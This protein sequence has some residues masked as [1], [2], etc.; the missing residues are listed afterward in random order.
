M[1]EVINRAVCGAVALLLRSALAVSVVSAVATPPLDT[2]NGANEAAQAKSPVK[3]LRSELKQ[4]AGLPK[5]LNKQPFANQSLTAA[6]A[7]QAKRVLWRH[8][9]A[10]VKSDLQLN[11]NRGVVRAA[12]RK[13]RF[14]YRV[15]GNKPAGG[16]SLFISLH[17]GG[18]APA[19]VNDRQWKNQARLYQ[20]DEG[21]Y[22]A[23]RAPTNAWNLWHKAHIDPLLDKLITQM[24]VARDVNPNKVY[25]LGYSAGGDGVYQLAPRM[26]D[27]W[28]AAS[29]MA[30]HPND[31]SIRGLRNVPFSIHVGGKDSAYDRNEIARKRAKKLNQLHKQ[32]PGGYKHWTPRYPDKGHWLDRED[33]RALSWMADYTRDPHPNRVVWVQDDVTHNR[34]YWLKV[35]E[36]NERPGAT[37]VAQYQ[38][39]HIRLKESSKV[40]E[41][42]VLL[43]DRMLNLDRPIKITANGRTLFKGK[44]TRTI[45]TLYQTLRSRGDPALV[46]SAA[47][48]V[49]LPSGD[50]GG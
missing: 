46:F 49:Q 45:A 8:R 38:G 17:G 4:E 7:K 15:Y 42:T 41:L 44:A 29:M 47:V 31:A 10:H 20:P 37:V 18:G 11:Q 21:V 16:R 3:A 9:R 27:R 1:R 40:D 23:P 48:T 50:A 28:A 25:L 2:A 19:R 12:G 14:I 13:M 36:Q 6:Q 32:D 35:D 24:I 43:N 30:G 26:A 5:S 34:L 33:A 39:Q 22:V